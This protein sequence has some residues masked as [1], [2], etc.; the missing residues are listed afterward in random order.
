[1]RAVPRLPGSSQ[2]EQESMAEPRLK[3]IGHE[4][5]SIVRQGGYSLDGSFVPLCPAPPW[6]FTEKAPAGSPSWDDV[7]VVTPEMSGE[8]LRLLGANS[9]GSE[10]SAAFSAADAFGAAAGE[11]S[12]KTLVLSFA[13]ARFPAEGFLRGA[14]GQ[15]QSLCRQ[16]TLYSSI[17]SPAA[18][19]MYRM[20]REGTEFAYTNCM[21]VSPSVCVFRDGTMKLLRE[22]FLT[23]VVT[24]P[25][26]NR[27]GRASSMPDALVEEAIRDRLRR[28][29]AT[30]VYLGYE[31]LVLGAW[32][33]QTFGNDPRRMA[34]L[35]HEVLVE[36][37]LGK[38]Y[39]KIVFALPNPKLRQ[40][41]AGALPE[42][43]AEA[44][45]SH[46]AAERCR[47]ACSGRS[48]AEIVR[49]RPAGR[50]QFVQ[51]TSPDPVCRP[52][53]SSGSRSYG[54][55]HGLT[56][57]GTPFLAEL[58]GKRRPDRICFLL[59]IQPGLFADFSEHSGAGLRADPEP[60]MPSLTHSLEDG[61]SETDQRR[62]DAAV[63]RLVRNRLVR[64]GAEVFPAV[65]YKR[66]LSG[67]W[68]TQIVIEFP[69]NICTNAVTPLI[70]F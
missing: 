53:K 12:Q 51:A 26:P 42:A 23:A 18:E 54:F 10:T 56:A 64:Q 11:D 46:M 30:G 16:S 37:G 41:F 2:P 48:E 29:A 4:T 17:T 40:I 9:D 25:A 38:Y 14:S 24:L 6:S 49:D 39:R 13:D 36:E 60:V 21:L 28:L 32:G 45:V 58:Y 7:L 20:N 31:K 57:D 8:Y 22:P 3:R 70:F 65:R 19:R 52:Q 35:M 1:M 15:E 5:L 66:D 63:K 55:A 34:E 50:R 27:N 47:E 43:A 59:P 44:G 61:G 68:L 33:C 62:I 69:H 67:R